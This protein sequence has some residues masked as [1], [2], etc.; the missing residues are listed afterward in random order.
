MYQDNYR[1]SE[2]ALVASIVTVVILFWFS[3][4][5]PGDVIVLLLSIPLCGLLIH[6]FE[7]L[8]LHFK[9]V[10]L[11][12]VTIDEQQE[13]QLKN[14]YYQQCFP[15]ALAVQHLVDEVLRKNNP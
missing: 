11:Y 9:E 15:T 6:P 12:D 13:K 5:I 7:K 1:V 3:K 14:R 4:D 2:K 10:R 8:F